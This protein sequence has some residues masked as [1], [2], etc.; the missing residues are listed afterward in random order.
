MMPGMTGFELVQ[1]IRAHPAHNKTPILMLTRKRERGDVKQALEVGVTDYVVKP[2]D[3]SLLLEKV[4]LCIKKGKGSH[5][6]LS[7]PVFDPQSRATIQIPCR[8]VSISE[9]EINLQVPI[10]IETDFAFELVNPVFAEIGIAVP[11]LKRVKCEKMPDSTQTRS[12]LYEV[13]F[14]FI[15]VAEGDLQKIRSW[16][17][18]QIVKMKK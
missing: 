18:R 9:S 14:S 13:K 3:E 5:H 17:Q 2:L 12:A 10:P 8:V 6:I 4:Q 1:N 11:L 16:L 15:G 7:A